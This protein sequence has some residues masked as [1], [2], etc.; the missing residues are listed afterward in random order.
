MLKNRKPG[1]PRTY[2]CSFC[3]KQQNQVERLIAGPG[4]TYICDECVNLCREIIEEEGAIR[5]PEE[6]AKGETNPSQV[7]SSCGTR[8]PGTYHYCF[9]CGQKLL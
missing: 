6:V 4:N 7:C 1:N 3:G 8:C 2:T 5:Q 9:N